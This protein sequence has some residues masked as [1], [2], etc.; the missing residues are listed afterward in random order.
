MPERQPS[1]QRETNFKMPTTVQLAT[2]LGGAIGCDFR[3]AQNQLVF[4]E[5]SGKLS[6]LNLSPISTIVAQS[7]STVLKGTFLFDFDSGVEGGAGPNM[8]VF[9]EQETAVLRRMTPQNSAQIVNLG[10]VDFNSIN[11]AYLQSL[12]YSTTPIPGNNDATNQLTV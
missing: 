12:P 8:D 11:A 1:I 3:L 2:G 6:A 9:W 4:V 7:T 10:A 5:Y